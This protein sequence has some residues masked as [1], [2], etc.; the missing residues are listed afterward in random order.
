MKDKM[1]LANL[2]MLV[3]GDD[4]NSYQK[5]LALKEYE[6]LKLKAE[7]SSSADDK[8][9]EIEI[10]C[11]KEIFEASKM[12][13]EMEQ[14][15]DSVL[16]SIRDEAIRLKEHNVIYGKIYEMITSRYIGE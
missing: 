12:A 8:L 9:A 1:D 14:M 4:L 6:E 2:E 10:L 13:G 11:V 15:P 7:Q 3:R 5:A 16:L